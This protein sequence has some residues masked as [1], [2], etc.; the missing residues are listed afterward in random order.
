MPRLKKSG[1]D[2]GGTTWR[3]VTMR[4]CIVTR[5]EWHAERAAYEAETG[6]CRECFGTGQYAFGW[7]VDTGLRYRACSRCNATGKASEVTR[8]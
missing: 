3:G 6:A 5:D 8:G 7:S 1:A 4:D 2:K